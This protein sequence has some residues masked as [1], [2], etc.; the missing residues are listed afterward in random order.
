ME[1]QLIQQ[2]IHE[3]RGQKVMLDYDL[4]AMYET[5]TKVL[6][7]AVKRNINRFPPDFMFELTAAEYNS[8]R[9]QIVT[10]KHAGRGKHSKYLPFAF[11]E[12]GV[13]ML[14]SVLNSERAIEVNIGIMRA[15]VAIRRYALTYTELSQR[16]TE[17]E[18]RSEDFEKALVLLLQDRKDKKDW[19]K[20]E[21]IG[22]KKK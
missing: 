11:T 21:R 4:A 12:Q 8:L 3:I 13:A 1:L 20:R 2:K 22:F 18:I 9:S 5:E 15:F 7:Q 10:L 6:K 17:L 14:S 16:L 19:E